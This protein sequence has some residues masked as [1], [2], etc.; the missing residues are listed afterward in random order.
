M[1]IAAPFRSSL[2]DKRLAMAPQRTLTVTE[3]AEQNNNFGL[4]ELVV[5][6]RDG[7]AFRVGMPPRITRQ[8]GEVLLPY[9][10]E[11]YE[12]TMKRHGSLWVQEITPLLD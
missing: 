7:R 2:A 8:K 11:R 10:D 9:D 5:V 6:A 1:N 12:D 3:A 4:R